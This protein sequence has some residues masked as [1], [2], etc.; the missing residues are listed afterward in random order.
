VENARNVQK[1]LENKPEMNMNKRTL[2]K[3]KWHDAKM[4]IFMGF[5]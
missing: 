1:S 3:P 2:S 4:P 5:L